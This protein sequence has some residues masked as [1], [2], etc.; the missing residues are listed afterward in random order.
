MDAA[1]RKNNRVERL[2]LCTGTAACEPRRERP[3]YGG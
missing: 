2:G 3:G 1:G